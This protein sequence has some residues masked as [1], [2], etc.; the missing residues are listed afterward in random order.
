MTQEQRI[1]L[2][3]SL[4]EGIGPT[5][6]LYI[7]RYFVSQQSLASVYDYSESDFKTIGVS[8][9]LAFAL[10]TGL[11][12]CSAYHRE[13]ELLEK[14][15]I[16]IVTFLDDEYPSLLKTIH[17]PPLVLYVQGIIPQMTYVACVGARKAN[18]YGYR[19]VNNI[20][21]SLVHSGVGIVSGGAFGVDAWS[22][23]AALDAAGV[24]IVV[25]GTGLLRPYPRAHIKLF[26]HIVYSGGAIISSF[27][28]ETESKSW[29]F[30]ARNRIIAGI[31]Q[32]TVVI[33]A[34][35]KSGALIT[36]EYALQ[37]GRSVCAVSGSI[38]D[39]MS[40]G[41]HALIGQGARLITS[42]TDILEE[43]GIVHETVLEENVAIQGSVFEE[44]KKNNVNS[45]HVVQVKNKK[46][47]QK[48]T[49]QN[50]S[51][52]HPILEHC[53]RPI[54]AL[55]LSLIMRVS[56]DVMC[57]MLFELQLEG[58]LQQDFAGLWQRA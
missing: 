16:R 29:Q 24:T 30:P 55:D 37:E 26:E 23:Q 20:I 48:D 38:E 31:A 52:E 41:C 54:T 10:W 49:I 15:N 57:Q 17:T 13:L 5:V 36:A 45:T 32:A 53:S 2:H 58:V 51:D 22:H 27:P 4:L 11:R 6:L 47:V 7:V 50:G 39:D 28:L 21:P 44:I 43:C 8:S 56:E 42:A 9:E 46:E 33:Q 14:N 12:D 34:A 1:L 3:L 40:A 35:A 18:D 19:V 25:L